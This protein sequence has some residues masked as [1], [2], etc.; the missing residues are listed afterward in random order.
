MAQKMAICGLDCAV[1]PAFI[2]HATGDGAL[3]EKTAKEWTEIYHFACTPEMI[4]CV[5][6][7]EEG[8]H[9]GHCGECAVRLCGQSKGVAHCGDCPDYETCPTIAGFLAQVP[10]AKANLEEVRAARM[11]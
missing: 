8:V 5:G 1:C 10:S 4:D 7:T 11:R 3:R 9:I 2:A 6:C